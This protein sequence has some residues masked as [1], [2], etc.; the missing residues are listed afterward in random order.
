VE[1]ATLRAQIERFTLPAYMRDTAN[2]RRLLPDGAY[3]HAK[4]PKGEQPFDVQQWFARQAPE[5][6]DEII[7][8][9]IQ[10]ISLPGSV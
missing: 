4:P 1:D 7:T 3:K 8:E 9:Q 2:A 5:L 6:L 10:P